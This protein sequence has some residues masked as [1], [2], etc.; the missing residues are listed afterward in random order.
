MLA[1]GSG[2]WTGPPHLDESER[3]TTHAETGPPYDRSRT[4]PPWQERDQYERSPR[5]TSYDRSRGSS[6]RCDRETYST[7]GPSGNSPRKGGEAHTRTRS[8]SR[9]RIDR[10]TVT[11]PVRDSRRS[12]F[13]QRDRSRSPLDEAREPDRDASP[14]RDD[15][16]YVNFREVI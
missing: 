15:E 14:E 1:V 13:T 11:P 6:P 4:T 2:R 7:R 10:D 5:R 3:T 16:E 8:T 9:D 12:E